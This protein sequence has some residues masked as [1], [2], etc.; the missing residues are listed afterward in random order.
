MKND[1]PLALVCYNRPRHLERV[2]AALRRLRPEPLYVFCDGPKTKADVQ[3]V[4][5][6]RELVEGI[7]WTGPQVVARPRNVGLSA[8]VTGAA[9]HVLAR[10]ETVVVLEDDCVPGPYFY[11]FMTG[12]LAR[13]RDEARVM[14][15]GGYTLPLPAAFLASYPHDAY[16][17]PRIESWGW[18]TW[19]RAWGL[20]ER[21]TARIDALCRERGVDT[22]QGGADVPDM[23]RS[24]IEGW[25]DAWTPAWLLSVYL[26]GGCCVYPTRSHVEN[27]GMDG[28]GVHCGQTDAWETPPAERGPERFPDTIEI[29]PEID[30]VYRGKFG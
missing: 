28:S 4:R 16:F 22:R 29:H 8:S 19:R 23:V 18:A 13:Y 20:Y 12:C 7:D 10:H 5:A 25:L 24:R 3:H 21:D 14:A 27:I 17:Y 26:H 9:D 2:L 6:V 15:V 1:H 11:A 30:K